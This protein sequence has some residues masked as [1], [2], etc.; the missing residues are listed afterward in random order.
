MESGPSR[1]PRTARPAR[2]CKERLSP[3]PGSYARKRDRAMRGSAAGQRHRELRSITEPTMALRDLIDTVVIV[4]MEN[5]SFDHVLGHL[6]YDGVNAKIEGLTPP[7]TQRSIRI[8][9]R[10]SSTRLGRMPRTVRSRS[11]RLMSTSRSRRS[12]ER[13]PIAVRNAGFRQ[14]IY[15]R[16]A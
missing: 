11:T 7:R 1:S 4:M 5:R 14:S 8:C 13:W 10:R 12:W 15:A 6:R 9:S 2:R 16:E 3:A